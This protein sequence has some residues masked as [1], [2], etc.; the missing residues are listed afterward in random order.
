[1][2]TH[3]STNRHS[4]LYNLDFLRELHYFYKKYVN[5]D[6]RVADTSDSVN[7]YGWGIE[8]PAEVVVSGL[9]ST[10]VRT[11]YENFRLNTHEIPLW[12]E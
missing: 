9:Y 12:S 11:I 5:K 4:L 7:I 8:C 2:I 10:R 1:M 3:V 6:N